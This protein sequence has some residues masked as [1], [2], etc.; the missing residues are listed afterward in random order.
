MKGLLFLFFFSFV[1]FSAFSETKR[2]LALDDIFH[3]EKKLDFQG[4][5]PHGIVWLK[6]SQSYLQ[7]S[8]ESMVWLKIDSITGN[9]L[10]FYNKEKIEK[11][12]SAFFPDKAKQIVEQGESFIWNFQYNG[13]IV[14]QE[15]NLYYYS[16]I[17]DKAIQ[18]TK[19]K[20]KKNEVAFS[21]DG[22]H[23][24]FV[25]DNNLYIVSLDTLEQKQITQDGNEKIYNG[26]LDWVYQEEIFGRGNFR[27]YWWSKDSQKIAF[28][29]LRALAP[30]FGFRRW[31]A[32]VMLCASL[33][34]PNRWSCRAARAV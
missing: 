12:L 9:G 20:D 5:V 13:F 28:L 2:P 3:P 7:F 22:K 10:P 1:L 19:S 6:D 16:M 17:A 33:A 32:L 11:A 26:I 27:G 31:P 15:E 23:I 21:P 34:R 25:I 30:R 8:G 14:E 24:S 29:R 18:V 4:S